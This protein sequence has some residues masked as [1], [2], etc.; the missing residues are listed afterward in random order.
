M[1]TG[2]FLGSF[3][4]GFSTVLVARFFINALGMR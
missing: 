4:A 3:F 2:V 1:H